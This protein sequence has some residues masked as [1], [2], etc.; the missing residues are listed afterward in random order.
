MCWDRLSSA[1]RF[2]CCA[3]ADDQPWHERGLFPLLGATGEE[4][5]WDFAVKNRA[6]SIVGLSLSKVLPAEVVSSRWTEAIAGA[7]KRIG[8]Y[9]TELDRVA[10]ACLAAGIPLV[11]LKN[12]G[13]ARGIFPNFAGCPMGDVDVLVDPK[14]FR[15]AHA[16]LLK[17]GYQLGSRSP[18]EAEDLNEAERHG[19]AEYT[20]ILPDGSTFWFEL[21]W[22]PVAGRW[23]R[24]DQEPKASDLIER[25]VRISGSAARL[26]SPEDN[27]LQ[28]S[29]HTAKHSYVRA[30][31]FRLHTDVD[32]IV[33]RC[34]IDWEAFVS[35]VKS[36]HVRTAVYLS[37]RIPSEMLKTPVPAWV[38]DA[39]CPGKHKAKLMLRW[40]AR[41]GFFDPDQK[42]W[43]KPGYILFNMMLYDSWGELWRGVFPQSA[44]MRQHYGLQNG[45]ALPWCYAKR[46]ANLVSKRANT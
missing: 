33:R 5:A 28:V 8:L 30:P 26:L 9:M 45:W 36:L 31:G 24:A 38:L 39:L 7:E 44:W 34:S 37:L 35:R 14:Q 43:S 10:S 32:R 1:E 25:S 20:L 27:L 42:K 19:G 16:I 41:A 11:A 23:I 15:S 12:S 6:D 2:F 29:L 13:I 3:I 21:Q 4:V 40:L 46:L 18:L 17:L 22:R